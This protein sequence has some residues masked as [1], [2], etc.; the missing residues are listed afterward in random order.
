MRRKE[1]V[2]DAHSRV[3]E[4]Q[5]DHIGVQRLHGRASFMDDHTIQ[6]QG[7]GR[8]QTLLKAEH[9]VIAVGSKPRAPQH[10]AIDHEHLLDSDSFLSLTYQPK[11]LIVMGSGVIACEYASVFHTL[12]TAVTMIDKYPSPL[13]FLD[14]DLTSRF[15]DALHHNGNSQFISGLVVE[16]AFY[17]A[18]EGCVIAR[19]ES[20]EEFKA[21]KLLCAAG[22]YA[23]VQH[24]ALENAGLSVTDRGVIAVNNFGQ[25]DIPHIYAVGDV[26]GPPSLGSASMDQGRRAVNHAC[27]H[28]NQGPAQEHLPMGIY[29]FPKSAPLA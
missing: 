22:R 25:T 28:P 11:S 8:K 5:L 27:G 26:I 4:E 18:E 10:V 9:I 20:G 3:H 6:I 7:I 24:L 2:L 1:Q 19:C 23:N 16:S 13:G 12:G 15:V 29:T 21:E 17:S 14:H